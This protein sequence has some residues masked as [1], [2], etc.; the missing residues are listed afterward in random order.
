MAVVVGQFWVCLNTRPWYS[1]CYPICIL[2]LVSATER[3]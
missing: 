1:T 2:Y 3:L